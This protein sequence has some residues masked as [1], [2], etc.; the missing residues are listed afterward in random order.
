M[1]PTPFRTLAALAA[2]LLCAPS[3]AQLFRA[4]LSPTGSDANPCTL[5]QPCRLLPAA[6]N[7]VASNGEIWMLGSANYNV[8]T[9]SV[10]R[11]VTILAIPGAVGSVVAIGGPA[12][13]IPVNDVEVS[14]RNVSIGPIP[15]GGGTDGV[16]MTG[17]STLLIEGSVMS[18]LDGNAITVAGAGTV[19]VTE[20]ILRDN[21]N[22]AMWLQGGATGSVSRTQILNN[23]A[24]GVFAL[25]AAFDATRAIVS[26]S[27]IADGN[28]GINLRPVANGS[29]YVTVTRSTITR[30][31][32]AL[33]AVND[34][35]GTA[36][37]ALNASVVAGNTIGWYVN[38]VPGAA[39]YSQQNNHIRDNVSQVGSLTP[40]PG[41]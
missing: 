37:I 7:A 5:P 21:G 33:D 22:Y 29:A 18:R 9:V 40:R 10:D 17:A 6:I 14:L 23:A 35:G 12:I 1:R 30:M 38:P 41:Y 11:S 19:Y 8:S 20:C 16:V 32:H 39:I 15:G 26:D 3:Q 28:V 4:Y 27:L 2:L 24:G 36:V 13:S 25:P 31:D 34:P